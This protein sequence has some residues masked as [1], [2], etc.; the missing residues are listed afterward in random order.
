MRRKIYIV[1]IFVIAFIITGCSLAYSVARYKNETTIYDIMDTYA[2]ETG[3]YYI[4]VVDIRD[5]DVNKSVLS[6]VDLDPDMDSYCFYLTRLI[7]V[8]IYG[9]SVYDESKN[10]MYRFTFGLK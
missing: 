2:E 7:D 4:G 8:D 9:M 5:G 3:M 1:S 10:I 6:A